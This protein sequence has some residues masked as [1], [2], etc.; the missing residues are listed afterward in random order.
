[1]PVSFQTP[2]RPLPRH[3]GQSS[4]A[5][6]TAAATSRTRHRSA[7]MCSRPVTPNEIGCRDITTPVL[8]CCLQRDEGGQYIKARGSRLEVHL[9]VYCEPSFCAQ[10]TNTAATDLPRLTPAMLSIG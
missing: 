9:V 10:S 3:S 1:M 4:A 6:R 5:S 2:R 7:E 8:L